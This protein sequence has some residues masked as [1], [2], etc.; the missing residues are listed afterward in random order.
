MKNKPK[1]KKIKPERFVVEH[2]LFLFDKWGF[3]P[4]ATKERIIEYIKNLLKK[5]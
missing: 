3:E 4:E 1:E 5:K 2:L